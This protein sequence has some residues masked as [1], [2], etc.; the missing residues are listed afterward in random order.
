MSS[1]SVGTASAAQ[2]L[3]QRVVE[4]GEQHPVAVVPGLVGPGQRQP[5]LARAGT[6]PHH[7][8]PVL[9]ERLEHGDLGGA[10]LDQTL[11]GWR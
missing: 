6:A 10:Q 3:G 9:G 4:A 1:S 11:A 8:P 5:G 2:A 7:D